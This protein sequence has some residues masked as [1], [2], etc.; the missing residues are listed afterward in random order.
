MKY[1]PFL[2]FILIFSCAKD[3]EEPS[4]IEIKTIAYKNSALNQNKSIQA[5]DAWIYIDD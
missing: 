5:S 3:A 1:L 4:Y 2:L